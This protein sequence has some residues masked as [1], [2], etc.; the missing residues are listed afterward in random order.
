MSLTPD[1]LNKLEQYL[2][3]VLAGSIVG[4]I[5]AQRRLHFEDLRGG[6]SLLRALTDELTELGIDPG[7]LAAHS[8]HALVALFAQESNADLITGQF[9]AL[10]WSILGD[11][12]NGG[13]PPE[14]YRRAGV[15]MHL[16]LLGILDPSIVEKR[17]RT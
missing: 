15:A 7:L 6:S 13:R 17:S 16:A 8:L 9:T 11:P 10:L 5:A 12:K 3:T 14:I 4:Q 2:G 1:D